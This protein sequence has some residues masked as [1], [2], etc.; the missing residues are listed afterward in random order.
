MNPADFS[1]L[2]AFGAAFSISTVISFT[3]RMAEL[4]QKTEDFAARLGVSNEVVGQ[5]AALARAGGDST[6]SLVSAIEKQHQ[7]SLRA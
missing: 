1:D 7:G 5:F 3:T 2:A 6:E 4:G